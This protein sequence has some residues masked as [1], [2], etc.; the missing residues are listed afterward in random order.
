MN[1]LTLYCLTAFGL[2]ALSYSNNQQCFSS[3]FSC[4]TCLSNQ[5]GHN[6]HKTFHGIGDA[7]GKI[8]TAIPG[9]FGA[10]NLRDLT[11]IRS[12]S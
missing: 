11:G 3:L 10:E 12:E 1:I 2:P 4:H 8:N 7:V 9:Y 5:Y 6:I